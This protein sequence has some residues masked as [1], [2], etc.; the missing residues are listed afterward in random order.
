MSLW[1]FISMSSSNLV[2]FQPLFRYSLHLSLLI[3][4]LPNAYVH[5]LDCLMASHRFLRLC[6]LSFNLFSFCSSV[7]I[8]TTVQSSL[9][10]LFSACSNLSLYS[11]TFFISV[12]VLFNSRISFWFLI[13]FS[14]SLMVFPFCSPLFS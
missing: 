12:T 14:L 1:I 4:G 13:R 2:S 10:I 7:S 6:S 9:L 3:L 5:L 11:I 8:I